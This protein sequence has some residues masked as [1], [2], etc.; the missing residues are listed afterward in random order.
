MIPLFARYEFGWHDRVFAF[1]RFTADELVLVAI[2]FNDSESVCYIDC[3]PLNDIVK[4]ETVLYRKVDLINPSNPQEYFTLNELLH[5][6]HYVALQ[7]WE[8]K[9]MGVYQH[10]SSPSAE[11]VLY[12]QSMQRLMKNLSN[13]VDPT[14]NL[15]YSLV[16]ANLSSAQTMLRAFSI[17]NQKL[18]ASPERNLASMTQTILY[19][20]TRKD[21]DQE[22]RT[23][24]YLSH[25]RRVVSDPDLGF[26]FQQTLNYNVLGPIVF[27]TPEIGRFSTV[28]GIG[29]MVDDLTQAL[30]SLGL[31][32]HI[33]SPYYNFNRK[34]KTDYLAAEGI[35]WVQ[36]LQTNVGNDRVE[37]GV[38]TG[39]ENGVNLHFLHNFDYFPTPY[40][41]GS[42]TYQ[43]ATIVLFAKAALEYCCQMR[44][45]PAVIVTNDWFAGLVPAYARYGAFGTTFKGTTFFHLVHNLE[46]GYEGKIY[47]DGR[48]L[49]YLHQ[50][51]REL[52]IDPFARDGAIN[53]SR[54]ALLASDQWGTVSKSY[55]H[56]LMQT[57]PLKSLL[58]RHPQPFAH[59]NG[60]RVGPR[61]KQMAKLAPDYKTAKAMIQQKYFGLEDPNVAIFSFVGRL[62]LQKGVHL[63]LQAV[64]ELLEI[65]K[66]RIQVLVGGM[67]NMKD[68]YAANCAWMMQGLRMQYPKNFWADPNEFFTDGLLI[69]MGSDFGLMPSLFE[70]SGVVQQEYFCAGTP[71]L[72]FKTGGL[73]D[74][75]FEFIPTDPT[76]TGNGFTFE[77]HTVGDFVYAVKRAMA[78]FSEPEQYKKLRK[79]SRESV[80]DTAVV[81]EA[82]TRE[83]CRLRRRMWADPE[84]IQKEIATL[85][86][87]R[88]AAS[89][90]SSP[91]A[92]PSSP[93]AAPTNL[94]ATAPNALNV[95]FSGP[96]AAVKS[97]SAQQIAK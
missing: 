90:S 25:L 17:L 68:S 33:I 41:T 65:F 70:P 29:V 76:T 84:I 93:A 80:L 53:A 74:T 51:P 52:L 14:H 47:P 5:E 42:A 83:Y 19:H 58:S 6:K 54:C 67:A 66:G 56:D 11:R 85:E 18:S 45:L 32:I 3:A 97:A 26:F 22:A 37:V 7:P 46:E 57:S 69:N 27:V 91:V 50:L 13:N 2:N 72:A 44:L 89:A 61:E 82:W 78:V 88:T 9:C 49:G 24:A 55:R 96:S 77:A 28:G 87:E 16:T 21:R 8:T 39:Q 95:T 30:V 81:A 62:T 12:E 35:K 4:D 43:L 60:I 40:N 31:E 20:A 94:S 36:N 10:V 79:N 86:K 48:D 92:V 64:R 71:V 75:V 63:I 59:S 38:H 23:L 73:K 34:G 15:I 1:A